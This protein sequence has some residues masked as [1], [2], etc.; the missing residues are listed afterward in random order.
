MVDNNAEAFRRGWQRFFNKAGVDRQIL[1]IGV[2]GGQEE[3]FKRFSEQLALY[4]VQEDAEPKPL[5]LVDSEEP[6]PAGS[7]VWQHLQTRSHNTFQQPTGADD[8]SAYMM[9]QSMETWFIADQ[10]ALQRFFKDPFD[11]SIFQ[12]L[13][14]LEDILKED[15]LNKLRQATS[16]CKPRYRKGKVSYDLL[17]KINPDTVAVACP[18]AKDLLNYLRSL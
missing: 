2:G 7:T 8:Q 4:G 15:A 6:V 13:P 16:R 10:P 9:V 5:L 18:H 17:A 11:A 1:E 12:S 14:S 3:A